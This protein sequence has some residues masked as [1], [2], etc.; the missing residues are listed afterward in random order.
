M[1]INSMA[2]IKR[3]FAKNIVNLI[4]IVISLVSFLVLFDLSSGTT[5]TSQD[6][7]VNLSASMLAIGVTVILVDILR[8]RR[9][10]SQIK[11]P[12]FIAVKKILGANSVL[13]LNLSIK[14]RTNDNS[15][16]AEMME[17]VKVNKDSQYALADG[18]KGA[19]EKLKEVGAEKIVFSYNDKELTT[20]FLKI[21]QNIRQSYTDTSD[22][23]IFS[24][25]DPVMRSDYTKLLENLDGVVGAIEMVSLS[26]EELEQY[27][28]AKEDSKPMTRNYFVGIV[29][30]GY[31]RSLNTFLEKYT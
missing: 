6:L 26:G 14:N 3:F 8:E 22:K 30:I 16:L 23:Y 1:V 11:V 29:L 4:I 15:I 20:E 24:F 10:E 5:G 13:A 25:S 21:V 7:L 12:R 9:L 27:L 2:E 19:L 28:T 18:A 31:L 17:F